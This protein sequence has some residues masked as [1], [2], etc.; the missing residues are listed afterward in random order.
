MPAPSDP[1]ARAVRRRE[2]RAAAIAAVLVVLATTAVFVKSNPFAQPYEIR[3]VFSTVA[4]L[5][6][7]SEVR[8]AGQRIGKVSAIAPG[9]GH[10]SL[11]TMEISERDVP[12][13]EDARLALEPRLA[14]EGNAYVL[15]R[16]GTP[17]ARELADGGTVPL[18]RTSVAVQLD[19]AVS[20]FDAPTRQAFAD[21]VGTFGGALG[22]RPASPRTPRPGV[23]ELRGAVREFDRSLAT[24][25]GAARAVRGRTPGDLRAAVRGSGDVAGQLAADPAALAGVLRNYATVSRTLA[26]R[27]ARLRSGLRELAQT[28]G[29]APAQLR[30][31]DAALPSL[32]RFATALEPALRS[33]PP[34]L[35]ALTDTA[36][37]VRLI[38]RPSEL[39]RL[40][41]RLRPVTRTLPVLERRLRAVLPQVADIGSCLTRTVVPALNLKVPDGH[42]STNRPVW[43]DAL[44]MTSSLAGAASGFDAN[45]GTLRL[46][47]TESEQAIGINTGTGLL[48]SK[49]SGLAPDGDVGMNPTW[50]GY[51]VYPAYR[52]DQP[53][54]EQR[55]P[56]LGARRRPGLPSAMR[57]LARVTP[58]RPDAAALR[59]LLR[60]IGDKR[61]LARQALEEVGR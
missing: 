50:L 13:R 49:L 41:A 56:D 23:T 52:P 21:V 16:P 2:L 30:A 51:N 58:Q 20:M 35:R 53:C 47:V 6:Q 18:S 1:A 44:H 39:P 22:S 24:L 37:E 34:A 7:G 54:D 3:G 38:A 60:Q 8:I 36:R 26:D 31:V 4:Q 33:A 28:L 29:A 27:D 48:G 32:T 59:K 45:G 57:R 40:L 12:I 43:Q 61:L 14:L 55:L 15:V 11:V 5:H 42:L 17:G 9:P 19:Q 46:G 25:T 10:T